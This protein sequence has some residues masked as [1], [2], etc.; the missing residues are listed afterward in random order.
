MPLPTPRAVFF[1]MDGTLTEPLLDF[2]QIRRDMGVPSGQPILEALARMPEPTRT[3]AEQVLHDHETTAARNSTLNP[4]AHDV[5]ARLADLG[6][7]TALITRNSRACTDIVLEAHDLP[8]TL[9]I[10]R[11]NAPYKPHPAPIL[12][13]CR[14]LDLDPTPHVWMVGDGS[15]D[16]A[17]ANAAGVTS[18]WLSHN[19]KRDFPD[20]PTHTIPA[21]AD[22]LTLLPLRA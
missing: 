15:H 13:A 4:G 11:E 19:Q 8:L 1:D 18:I 12:L 22:L 9:L 3:R 5:L 2:Q 16:V 10:T 21:L 7:P 17:S 14:H 6:L 20:A